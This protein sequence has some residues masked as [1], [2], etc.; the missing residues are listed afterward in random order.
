MM[1]LTAGEG[2]TVGDLQPGVRH[3]TQ[4]SSLSYTTA[5]GARLQFV[6]V[7]DELHDHQAVNLN[8]L[9]QVSVNKYWQIIIFRKDFIEFSICSL[10]DLTDFGQ[11]KHDF[12]NN[13]HKCNRKV[14][15]F[16]DK[17]ET[18]IFNLLYL[19]Q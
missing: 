1:K 3:E 13:A 12:W 14:M 4:E 9:R 5:A 11:K 17:L 19:P 16:H 15:D 8:D 10:T 6:T 7:L 18:P 2:E